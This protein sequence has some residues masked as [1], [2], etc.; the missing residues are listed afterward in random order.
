MITG[1][2]L[3]ELYK[4]SKVGQNENTYI[5]LNES[6]LIDS[7]E[8]KQKKDYNASVRISKQ[9]RTQLNALRR[10]T[11]KDNIDKLIQEMI[12]DQISKLTNHEKIKYKILIEE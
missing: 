4:M 11:K 1:E 9:T 2:N 5:N 12:Q 6:F 3:K 7:Q 10:I 8:N